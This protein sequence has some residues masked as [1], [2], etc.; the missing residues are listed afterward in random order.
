MG[1]MTKVGPNMEPA[2]NFDWVAVVNP[3]TGAPAAAGGGAGT[4][5]STEATQLLVKA[6]VETTASDG[7]TAAG[8]VAIVNA[9]EA[10]EIPAPVGG[11]LEATQ[12][13]VLSTL[14]DIR[15]DTDPAPVVGRS[16]VVPATPTVSTSAYAAGDCIG[17]KMTFAN[18]ARLAG[19]T[20]LVQTAMIQCKSAQT[21]AADL[22]I[23]HTDPAATTFTDNAAI[24]VNAA[25]F[26]KIA[27]RIPFVAGDW[28]NVGTPSVAEVSA[29][30]KL[31]K[32]ATGETSL[33]GVLVSR[34]TP[35]LASTSDLKVVLK[36]MQD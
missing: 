12:Q 13:D 9:I 2:K 1:T 7:A 36:A 34:G 33:Y 5:D 26:D 16:A 30:G 17:G 27:L 8:Q 19:L 24:A 29:Q 15:D 25:D 18:M 14:V 20:G 23:F 31:Y 21:F 22:I 11:S 3:A 6:A 4:S 32:A 35:T 10:I 28:S